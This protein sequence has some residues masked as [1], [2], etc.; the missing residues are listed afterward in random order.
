MPVCFTLTPHGSNEP[1]SLT[2]IDDKMCA[3]FGVMPD[4]KYYYAEWVDTEGLSLAMGMDWDW[5]RENYPE[6]VEIINFLAE[7]YSTECWRETSRPR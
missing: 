1:E 5:L 7:R 2:S 3:Y 4:E 6:R